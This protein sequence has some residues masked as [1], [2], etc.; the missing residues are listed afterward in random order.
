M[1]DFPHLNLKQRLEGRYHFVGPAID[2]NDNPE[3]TDNLNDRAGHGNSLMAAT[4][5]LIGAHQSFLEERKEAGLP[6]V[7]S[8]DIIPVFLQVDPVDFDIEALKG[9]GIEIIAEEEGGFIIGASAD[10]F[11]SLH[12]KV[13]KFVKEEGRTKNVAL[14]WQIEQGVQWRVEHILSPVLREKYIAGIADDEIFTVDISVACYLDMPERP[15]RQEE[16]TE[17]R[18]QELKARYLERGPVDADGNP[19]KYRKRKGRESDDKYEA[20]LARW[21]R[22]S[23][24]LYEL[25]D[26]LASERQKFLVNFIENIYKGSI[27]SGFIDMEDSFGFK[28]TLPGIGLKDLIKGYAYVFEIAESEEVFELP[29]VQD[30]TSGQ[31]AE[32]LAPVDGSPIVC[33]VDSGIQEKHRLLEAAILPEL[34]KNYVPYES[35]TSDQVKNGGHGTK[36][37]GAVLYA[38]NIPTTGSHESVCYLANARVLDKDCGLPS[39]LYPPQL[40]NTILADLATGDRPVRIFNL[41]VASWGPCRTIHMSP[42]A[43]TIDRLSH[44]KKVLFLLAAGNISVN[45]PFPIRLGIQQHIQ[46]GRLYPAY[47]LESSCRIANPA[48]SLFGLTVGSVC[49]DQFE[50]A[51]RKSFGQRDHVSSFSRAG[52]GLWG[53]VK[54][55]VVEYGGDYLCEKNG[56]LITQHDQTSSMVVQTGAGGVGRSVGTSFATPK[57]AHIAASLASKFPNE[58]TLL[59]KALIVQSA[60]LPEH[61]FFQPTLQSLQTLGYG[62]PDKQ[63]A[64]E[65]TP[66]RVTF[67]AEGSVCP[68]QANLYSVAIPQEINRAGPNFDI[69][70]EVTLTFTARPRRTRRRLKSYLSSWLS[71]DCSKSGETFDQFSRRV[72]K[73][74]ETS[75]SDAPEE[76]TDSGSYRW[77]LSSNS[78]WGRVRD[79][80][81]QDSATQKDWLVIKSNALG[82]EFSIAIVGHKGWNE[83]TTEEVPF[84]LAVSFEAI[85][86]EAEIYQAIELHNRIEIESEAEVLAR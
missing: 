56:Y 83:D 68:Q 80:K 38:N 52:L 10:N 86:K 28:A 72:L 47:L 74:I 62:I 81:R 33:V 71:W 32:I 21:S 13:D 39:S 19:K 44:E 53:S 58:T 59:Y 51:D 64:L 31:E 27:D 12:D 35:T 1:A 23:E 78:V 55:D 46:A 18:Y 82:S 34:S 22:K 75:P 5:S 40:M 17:E 76:S 43:A 15:A 54:P 48:Q 8:P 7:F 4:S 16:E 73:E 60:R 85:S 79:I 61:A 65:N 45:S 42:W 3:T 20:R 37:A 50:D 49:L 29:P 2:K 6:T 70:V 57:V 14:L 11:R 36:V 24:E 69:L 84:A 63:R 41:S 9:F 25:R 30:L 77:T 26:G 67:V 66:Y